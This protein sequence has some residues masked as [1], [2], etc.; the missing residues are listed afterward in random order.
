MLGMT[1]DEAEEMYNI[2]HMR[3]SFACNNIDIDSLFANNHIQFY[4]VGVRPQ[5]LNLHICDI[6]TNV[7]TV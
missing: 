2:K 5:V 4:D 7:V 3:H 1:E 6:N